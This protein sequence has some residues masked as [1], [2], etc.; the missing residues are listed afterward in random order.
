MATWRQWS[1]RVEWDGE[2]DPAIKERLGTFLDRAM[3]RT[4]ILAAGLNGGTDLDIVAALS[5]HLQQLAT[6]LASD[7][8]ETARAI[9]EWA[10]ETADETEVSHWRLAIAWTLE[11]DAVAVQ[12]VAVAVLLERICHA[13]VAGRPELDTEGVLAAA[14]DRLEEHTRSVLRGVL[15]GR[16]SASTYRVM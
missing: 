11:D 15:S 13:V 10:I 1:T 7:A 6:A 12:F 3:A 16:I 5:G 14:T 2:V 8:E 4:A 9:A